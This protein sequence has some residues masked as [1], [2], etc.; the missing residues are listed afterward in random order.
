[1]KTVVAVSTI[2]SA[3]YQ[4]NIYYILLKLYSASHVS[5]STI[6]VA[7]QGAPLYNVTLTSIVDVEMQP[8]QLQISLLCKVIDNFAPLRKW[9]QFYQRP[10][11]SQRKHRFQ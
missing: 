3:K 9:F 4:V 10:I 5:F 7:S 1:M 6:Q 11:T 2:I 8:T